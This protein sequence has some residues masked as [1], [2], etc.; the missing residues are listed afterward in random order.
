MALARK[1]NPM[2]AFV[3]AALAKKKLASA[4]RARPAYQKNDWL[5]WIARAARPETR[6]KRLASMLRELKAGR[7]YMG[8]KWGPKKK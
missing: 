3:R 4:F 5:G 1:K 8:M 2:P 7:G 6:A